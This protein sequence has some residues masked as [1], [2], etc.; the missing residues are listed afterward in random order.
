MA[1]HAIVRRY[2][3]ALFDVA[4]RQ[5]DV[6]RVATDLQLFEAV[7]KRTPRLSRVLR[8]PTIAAAR[9]RE[10]VRAGFAGSV[11]DLTLRFLEM[12]VTKQRE[13]ILPG[14]PAEFA[15]LSYEKRNIMPV[16]VTSAV[17]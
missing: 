1:E 17:A 11:G 8:A 5:G 14:V 2:A 13:A 6:D 10:L 9:K 12:V 7:L 3:K 15:R 4:D 16:E